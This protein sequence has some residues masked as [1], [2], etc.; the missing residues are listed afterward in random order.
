M[1]AMVAASYNLLF[2]AYPRCE[3]RWAPDSR[4]HN[5]RDSGPTGM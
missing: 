3:D 5:A 1:S 4:V 2:T